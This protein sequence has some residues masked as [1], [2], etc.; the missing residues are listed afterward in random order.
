ML[1]YLIKL[2][3]LEIRQLYK[4]ELFIGCYY[5]IKFAGHR[6][7]SSIDIIILVC[8]EIKQ[9]RVI[10]ESPNYNYR[11]SSKQV[12]TLPGLG[13]HRHCSSEDIMV[14]VCHLI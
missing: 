6:Y 11:S 7:C 14:L 1:F 8:Y 3:D 2:S 9:D 13:G 4:L 5:L 10:K 12:T